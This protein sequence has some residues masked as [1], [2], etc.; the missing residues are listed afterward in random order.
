MAS[1][2]FILG[3]GAVDRGNLRDQANIHKRVERPEPE[4][5]VRPAINPVVDRRRRPVIGREAHQWQPSFS[6]CMMSEITRRLSTR[7]A[8]GWFFGRYGLIAAHASFDNQKS[9][10]PH[11]S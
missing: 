8:P 1:A 7:R 10:L 9:A 4:A 11:S 2:I 5:T 6:T 3:V